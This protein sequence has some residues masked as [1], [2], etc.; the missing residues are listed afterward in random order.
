M[1]ERPAA[2]DREPPG[3]CSVRGSRLVTMYWDACSA[4]RQRERRSGRVRELSFS[5]MDRLSPRHERDQLFHDRVGPHREPWREALRRLTSF[6]PRI[7]TCPAIRQQTQLH[8]RGEHERPA[9][10]RDV[11]GHGRG[12]AGHVVVGRA[13]CRTGRRGDLESD[14]ERAGVVPLLPSLTTGLVTASASGSSSSIVSDAEASPSVAFAGPPTRRETP[15]RA[16]RPLSP[17]T[18][19]WTTHSTSPRSERQPTAARTQYAEIHFVNRVACPPSPGVQILVG[20][21]G[22]SE[23]GRTCSSCGRTRRARRLRPGSE[24]KFSP[25]GR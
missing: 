6:E 24:T 7:P 2:S 19:T 3:A 21:D 16:R 15:R 18:A 13:R 12:D 14:G 17:R 8:A 10:G 20:P 1:R 23:A 4:P 22:R 5:D 11:A 9:R 25:A